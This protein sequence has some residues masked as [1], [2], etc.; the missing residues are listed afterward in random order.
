[1]LYFVLKGAFF[2]MIKHVT[3]PVKNQDRALDFYTKKLGFEVFVDAAFGEGQR[4]IELKLPGAETQV[5]LFT[6]EGQED[7]IGTP[8]NIIFSCD[9]IE[10]K[11]QELK[12]RGV[13]FVQPPTQES[14]G[15][16]A[17][18]KGVDGNL[19]CLSTT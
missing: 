19:F 1:M 9:D 7:R 5:V 3:I 10:K 15:T 4:W 18:F 17:L 11:Y 2:M 12:G 6:A 13:E 14:W 16:Y 8:S